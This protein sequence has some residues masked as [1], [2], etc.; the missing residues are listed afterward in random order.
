MLAYHAPLEWGAV[1]TGYLGLL[2]FGGTCLAVGLLL[3][4]LTENQI[5]AGLLTFMVLL[6]LWVV[7]WGAEFASG[8]LRTVI[9]HLSIT[10][11]M[12]SFGKGVLETRDVAYYLSLTAVALFATLRS[13]DAKRWK[14]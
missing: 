14:G 8:T 9:R 11:H 3:S 2:L 5:V 1:A 10:E 12:D 4:S 13:L 7:G 6:L